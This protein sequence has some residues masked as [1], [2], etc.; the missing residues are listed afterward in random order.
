M[1]RIAA[2]AGILVRDD[3]LLLVRQQFR[4]RGFWSLPGG[5]VEDGESLL[6]ALSRELVEETGLRPGPV[7]RLA[8]VTELCTPSF[9]STAHV[10]VVA[11]WSAVDGFAGDPAGEVVASEFVPLSTARERIATL[12]F[13]AMREPLLGYLSGDTDRFYS[14][15]ADGSLTE[16][17]RTVPG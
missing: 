14:Y 8:H 15:V 5:T 4:V 9:L 1:R 10:F 6:A 17:R 3:R 11:G 7:V 13:P 16:A 12:P 2:V